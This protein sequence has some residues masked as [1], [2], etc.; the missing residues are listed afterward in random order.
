M[1]TFPDFDA[2]PEGFP[3]GKRIM[4]V[5][6]HQCI[7]DMLRRM[8][9]S[10]RQVVVAE[11]GNGDDAVNLILEHRPDI[12][13]LDLALEG[14]HGLEVARQARERG[15]SGS[16]L[17]FTGQMQPHVLNQ[18]R[19]MHLEAAVS[20]VG[21]LDYWRKGLQSLLLGRAYRCPVFEQAMD[22]E[23]KDDTSPTRLLT[24]RE[25]EI[26]SLIGMAKHNQEIADKLGISPYTVQG[27]RAKLLYKLSLPDSCS[28]VKFAQE[29][30]FAAFPASLGAPKAMSLAHAAGITAS[31]LMSNAMVLL[32]S[33]YL[34]DLPSA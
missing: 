4:L 27:V 21:G 31:K 33:F 13:V 10:L 18:I 8:L 1:P 15:Y 9:I 25:S 22:S 32:A 17:V 23:L 11:T 16:F 20:K 3:S 5:D 29:Q 26:L 30:G 2:Q 19:S 14:M 24:K 34:N 12:V 7:R 6:D 28:L